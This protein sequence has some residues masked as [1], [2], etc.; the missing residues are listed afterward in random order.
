MPCPALQ[1]NEQEET[2]TELLDAASR[3]RGASSLLCHT[4]NRQARGLPS[5]R[6]KNV[7]LCRS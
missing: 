3:P 1:A 2:P 7:G 5:I 4:Y 6:F